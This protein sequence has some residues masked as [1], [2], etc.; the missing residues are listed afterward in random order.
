MKWSKNDIERFQRGHPFQVDSVD[1]NILVYS[2]ID[3]KGKE[4]KWKARLLKGGIGLTYTVHHL[5]DHSHIL[6]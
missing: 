6:D 4:W 5:D 2:Y 3:K 1:G